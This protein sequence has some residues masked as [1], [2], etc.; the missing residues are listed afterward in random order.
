MVRLP[1]IKKIRKAVLPAAGLGTRFLPATKA[2]P[3]EML[4]LVD[5]PLIQYSVEEARASGI[6]DI[7]FITNKDKGA[8][9]AHFSRQPKIERILRGKKKPDILKSIAEISKLGRFRYITQAKAKGLGH[10]V[11]LAK[12]AVK[13]E[14][15][16][17]FLGDDIIDSTVPAMKQMTDVFNEYSVSVLAVQRVAKSEAHKYGIV[18]GRKVAPGL[19]KVSALVEKPKNPQSNLAIIGRYILTP[20]IFTS[21]K[22]TKTGSGGEVQLT[23]AINDLLER[24][25]VYALEFEGTRYDAG[26]KL[27]YLKAQVALGIKDPEA[28][29]ELKRFIRKLKI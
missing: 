29:K 21:L 1:V 6:G 28:G 23:D 20:E 11:L 18:E 16:A 7:I 3:K 19:Y 15:F 9:K 14:P 22:R 13:N 25:D 27:G 10:A 8:L 24:E 5:K 26:D 2:V 12:D 17:V 4:T